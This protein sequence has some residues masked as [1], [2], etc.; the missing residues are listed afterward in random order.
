M[1]RS[2]F[3]WAA[4][5]FLCSCFSTSLP[6]CASIKSLSSPNGD[7][8]NEPAL[9]LD[10]DKID[11]TS[12]PEPEPPPMSL[13]A[14]DGTGL[15]LVSL[16]ARAVVDAPL[17]YTE[18]RLVFENPDDRVLEGT[19][20]IALPE[21]ASISRFAMKIGALWQEGE[22]VTREHAREA[23]ED[24]LHRKQDPAL[25]EQAAGNEFSARVFPIPAREKKEIILS[26]SQEIPG[27]DSYVLP[28][29]GLPELGEIDVAVS[30]AEGGESLGELRT[31][32]FKP[33]AD[34]NV[35]LSEARRGS[36]L[37]SENLVLARIKPIQ[38]SSPDPIAS[39][40]VL[41]DTSASRA[42]GLVDQARLL[43]RTIRRI[44]DLSGPKTPLLVACYDQ[45]IDVVFEGEAGA[46]GPRE[47]SRIVAR[48]ALGASDLAGALAWV[49]R[50]ADARKD[51]RLILISDGVATA[52]SIEADEIRAAAAELK[53]AGIERIDAIAVGGIRDTALLRH[54][55]SAGLARDGIV[56][57]GATDAG[58]ANDIV[59]RIS[60]ATRSG[61]AVKIDGARWVYPAMLDGVQAGD[62]AFIYADVPE[63]QPVMISIDGAPAA[64]L[65]LRATER[66]LLERSF[67][68]AKIESLLE[69]QA[70]EG[71]DAR[72]T[73]EIIGLSTSHRVLSPHTSL[74]VLETEA[75]YVRF[76]IDR[77]ALSDILTVE[78]GR[79][80]VLKRSGAPA[81][82]KHDK[83]NNKTNTI[84]AANET[85][86]PPSTASADPPVARP[87]RSERSDDTATNRP[88]DPMGDALGLGGLGRTGAG[89]G[90]PE[91]QSGGSR[92]GWTAGRG[93]IAGRTHV[94]RP[95]QVRMGATKVSGRL[96]PEVIR[97]IVRR[98]F[99][100]FKACY[101]DGLRTNPKL[102]G[103][104]AVRFTI[105]RSGEI[106]D[107]S[108]ASADLPNPAVIAC[109]KRTFAS[110]SFPKPEGGYIVVTYPLVF[111]PAGA[112]SDEAREPEAP[113]TNLGFSNRPRIR[114]PE[115]PRREEPPASTPFVGEFKEVTDAIAAG[116]PK[117]ALEQALAWR[118]R[119]PGN[120][121]ALV[122]LGE[123]ME[124][125]GDM[126]GA[127]R[128]YGSIIDLFPAR[129]DLRRFAGGRLERLRGNAGLDLA[130]DSYKKAV[131]DRPDH[132]SSHRMLAMAWLKKGAFEQAFEAARA[133]LSRQYPP[134][135]FAGAQ[136]ILAEDLGL[137]A[138]AWK[139]AEP[140]KSDPIDERL[141]AAGGTPEETPSLR[142]VLT[143]ETDAND[144]D[145][146]IYDAEGGHAYFGARDLWRG[147]SLYDDVRTGYGP[148][149]FT[150][151]GPADRRSK[152]YTLLAHY[153]SRG[154]MG[155]GMGK[156]QVIEHDGKGGISFEERPFIA[157]TDGAYVN[158]G[159]VAR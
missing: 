10:R 51:K 24:F 84:V 124:A 43:E 149:C 17:A 5:I 20:R 4:G 14:S 68:R 55:T 101:E 93:R 12:P 137:I 40:V 105:E 49:R 6:A 145:F 56:V 16:T 152:G 52:G 60:E 67:V 100:R 99:N 21:R 37:R 115:P 80:A 153:Y 122:A 44:A 63:G 57:D 135:R 47:V 35:R 7:A 106:T 112:D 8:P 83:I 157:M 141:R 62:E 78:D 116:S 88:S 147:G 54:V 95:P 81:G 150:I 126:D 134:G 94:A 22:V 9:A 61:V 46:F 154:P 28:L 73:K 71:Q 79:L 125:L 91:A 96:P 128:S 123:A 140:S 102:E 142:F 127:A 1:R 158:L 19:F 86:A 104:V 87:R 34:L 69:R 156:I 29:R 74:L 138:A 139:K 15:R 82:G 18:L 23:Y 113:S 13:T 64:P 151:R 58:D 3:T 66:P 155:Y 110:L 159:T 144:V 50:K 27:N 25:L 107:V 33:S 111:S 146:H 120:V 42:A 131:A 32:H 143:W 39:A 90:G 26:Y 119:D 65:E 59:R 53:L 85:G 11:I 36:G 129:A 76:K 70:K 38:G 48:R 30:P 103:R 98:N 130:L 97:W 72:I 109:V 118:E 45:S 92:G 117:T 31:Q 148:E 75:D 133:G 2:V 89:E 121:M 41:M 77:R 108:V 136:R 114:L 132:P